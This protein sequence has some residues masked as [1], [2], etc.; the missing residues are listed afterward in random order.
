MNIDL[1]KLNQDVRP[2]VQ[3]I[4]NIQYGKGGMFDKR[5]FQP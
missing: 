2:I 1:G 3:K 4:Y 5:I